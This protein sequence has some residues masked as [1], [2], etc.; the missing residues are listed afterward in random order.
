MIIKCF[1][2]LNK[3]IDVLLSVCININNYNCILI[4]N[5]TKFIDTEIF[6]SIKY[7]NHQIPEFQEVKE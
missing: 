7:Y 5:I 3:I 1:Y 2:F 6:I 4:I